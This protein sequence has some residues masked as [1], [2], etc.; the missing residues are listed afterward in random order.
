MYL[1]AVPVGPRESFGAPGMRASGRLPTRDVETKSGSLQ[2]LQLL[3]LAEP[4]LHLLD[5]LLSILLLSVL[6]L[7]IHL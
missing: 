3:L 2:E 1:S 6:F 7:S 4:S 5:I